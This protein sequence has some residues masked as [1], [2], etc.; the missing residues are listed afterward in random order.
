VQTALLAWRL[1]G[2]GS[3][4]RAPG[5]SAN[6]YTYRGPQGVRVRG[7]FSA[8]D[9]ERAAGRGWL[10]GCSV[11]V[12]TPAALGRAVACGALPIARLAAVA[13]DEAD[14]SLPSEALLAAEQAGCVAAPPADII[15]YIPTWE[16]PGWKE[17]AEEEVDVEEAVESA[18]APPPLQP[19]EC[20]SL[21]RA[22]RAAAEPMHVLLAGATLPDSCISAARWAGLLSGPE[23]A[24]RVSLGVPSFLPPL[25]RH[26]L[27]LLPPPPPAEEA[28]PDAARFGLAALARLIRADAAA[29]TAVGP[30]GA[31]PRTIVFFEDE[32][33]AAAAAPA[34]RAAL[35]GLHTIAVLLPGGAE[36]TRAQH[37]FRDGAASLLLATPEAERGMD[38]PAVRHV[39]SA[40]GAA[41]GATAY[42]HRAGRA[43]RLGD[44]G[45]GTVTTLIQPAEVAAARSVLAEL[46]VSNAEELDSRML[47]PDEAS[48]D[49]LAAAMRRLEDLYTVF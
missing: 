34:L 29:A 41:P 15:P 22:S 9:V 21:W 44:G 8:A 47:V 49:S 39:Y 25:L 5:D 46:G 30:S 43:G 11:V 1:L 27:L 38:W 7:L 14:V 10:E 35:W 2:G 18:L 45:G 40:A 31:S 23:E 13:V 19:H 17:D 26:R 12:G 24:V 32:E 36:P 48:S 3:P 37:A 20:L 6:M 16:Q 33:A 28:A 42:L 4:A